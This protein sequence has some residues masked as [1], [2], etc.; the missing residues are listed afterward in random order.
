MAAFDYLMV[1][2]SIVI[3][4]AITA[5]LSGFARLIENRERV[6]FYWLPIFWALWLFVI[7][8][9]HWWAKF[10]FHSVTEWHFNAFV[11]ALLTPV[12]LFLLSSIVLPQVQTMPLIDMRKWYYENRQWFF[13]L[14]ACLPLLSY[15]EEFLFRGRLSVNLNDAGLMLGLAFFIGGLI[16][17][18]PRIHNIIA[19][20]M[21]IV[22]IVFIA[23]IFANLPP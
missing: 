15:L 18:N 5:V 11:V 7:S 16:T 13:G 3:G 17:A 22:T 9:Q 23:L 1:L 14:G 6:R 2:L 20:L 4:L 8:V 10:E 19:V 21:A 12:D